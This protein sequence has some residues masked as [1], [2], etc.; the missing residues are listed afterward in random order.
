ME[1]LEYAQLSKLA[2]PHSSHGRF[3]GEQATVGSLVE[4]MRQLARNRT[5]QAGIRYAH[6]SEAQTAGALNRLVTESQQSN[7]NLHFTRCQE[8]RN[9][10]LAFAFEGTTP[11]KVTYVF[12]QGR[13][14][15]VVAQLVNTKLHAI[16]PEVPVYMTTTRADF[17]Y[18]GFGRLQTATT[19]ILIRD[20]PDGDQA[21]TE[22]QNPIVAQM[23]NGTVTE[24]VSYAY[25]NSNPEHDG[26]YTRTTILPAQNESYV[27]F[28]DG[29]MM[30]Q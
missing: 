1:H 24:T 16:V 17:L 20:I 14:M 3:Y 12:E 28:V 2:G 15:T 22:L 27:K 6:Y 26:S 8:G 9:Q 13:L 21:K 4:K 29:K 30:E 19:A 25:G 11:G 23:T 10:L 5:P 18:D 7:P